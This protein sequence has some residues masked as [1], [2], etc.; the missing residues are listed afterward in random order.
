MKKILL[1][2]MVFFS[3]SVMAEDIDAQ[4]KNV[5]LKDFL[6]FVSEFTGKSVVYDENSISGN[7][8]IQSNSKLSKDNLIEIMHSVL[9]VNGYYAIDKGTY[10]QIV[11]KQDIREYNEDFYD[12][13]KKSATNFVTAL[14]TFDNLD[15]SRVAQ[16]LATIKS[17]FGNF[18]I[19]KDVNAVVVS[20][21]TERIIKIKDILR[22]MEEYAND[23]IFKSFSIKNSTA[24]A[25]DN[26][27]KEFFKQFAIQGIL[28]FNPVII[29]DDYSN[30]LIVGAKPKDI[31]K[32]EYLI[33]KL[34]SNTDVS[35][36]KPQV[37]RIKNVAAEDVEKILNKLL[38]TSVDPKKQAPISSKVASDKSTNS[39]IALGD[40]ELYDNIASLIE[41]LDVPRKQVYIEAL[42][43][44]TSIENGANFGVEWLAGGGNSNMAGSAGFLNNGSLTNFQAPVLDGNSPNFAALPGGFTASILGNIITYEGVKFPTLSALVNF[45][46]TDSAINIISNP[47]ILTLDNEEAEV[48]VGENRPYLTS[49]KFDTNNNPIQSYDYRDVGIRLKVTPHISDNNTL[50][51]KI[52]QEVKKV[53]A[54]ATSTDLTAPI[55]L[56][57][58]TRTNVELINGYTMVISGLIGDDTSV[59]NSEVPGLSKIPLLGWLFK[60]RNK[61]NSKTNMM[62]FISAQIINTRED[63]ELINSEKRQYMQMMNKNHQMQLNGK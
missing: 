62:V 12:G 49:T 34:D 21:E 47:Q 22:T 29:S 30:T 32:A 36:V 23:F 43:L 57:R 41:K 1:I 31:E 63:L 35:A 56:T 9:S 24:S 51:L 60:S 54:N 37:Y 11:K 27:L 16:S 55:T 15:L 20:D 59:S 61:S 6:L 28:P 26:K 5:S 19:V 38:A 18:Q 14:I 3:F 40:K 17:K 50:T 10:Y 44:E 58:Q 42:I 52:D 25:I 48:F 13:S 45:V 46:K 39:I 8:T 7:I 2:I 53:I 4:F 33:D